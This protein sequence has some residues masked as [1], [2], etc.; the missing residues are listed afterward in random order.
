MFS[1]LMWRFKAIMAKISLSFIPAFTAFW[2][3]GVLLGKMN[4]GAFYCSKGD[5]VSGVIYKCTMDVPQNEVQLALLLGAAVFVL[6]YWLT[7]RQ[8]AHAEEILATPFGR[9]EGK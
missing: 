1:N 7:N 9:S 5:G 4:G 8:V 2:M 6:A 3:M